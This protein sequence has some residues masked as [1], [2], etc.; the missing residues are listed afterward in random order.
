MYWRRQVAILVS[1]EPH[2]TPNIMDQDLGAILESVDFVDKIIFGK[3]NYN[4][5]CLVTPKKRNL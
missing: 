3:L 4:K 1:I 5:W 2:P